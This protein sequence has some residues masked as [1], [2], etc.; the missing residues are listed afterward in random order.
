VGGTFTECTIRVR[1]DL[2][3]ETLYKSRVTY[4][5]GP[6]H[7]SF[8]QNNVSPLKISQPAG[9]EGRV[10][11]GLAVEGAIFTVIGISGDFERVVN[12]AEELTAT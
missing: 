3:G 2:N 7:T 4:Y 12:I 5:T 6:C 11:A 9:F 1:P 10:L 8:G